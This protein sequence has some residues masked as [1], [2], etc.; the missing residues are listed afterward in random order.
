MAEDAI[1]SRVRALLAKAESTP[2]PE[3]AHA[4]TAKAQELMIR[5]AIDEAMLGDV[6][7]DAG[8][9]MIMAEVWIE[10][11]F[12]RSKGALLNV[13]GTTNRCWV[14]G[15]A[16]T[17]NGEAKSRYQVFG[18]KR[19]VDFVETLFTSLLLQ[20]QVE[21]VK[22]ECDNENAG[23]EMGNMK[24][25]RNVFMVA[26][27]NGIYRRLK[28]VNKEVEKEAP[29]VGLVLADQARQAEAFGR[30]AVGGLVRSSS[31]TVRDHA[32]ASKAGSDAAK[33]ASIHKGQMGGRRAIGQG[34]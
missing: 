11:P 9:E 30:E 4:F 1:L 33:R 13:V 29:G 8:A 3:E 16:S 31:R 5:H 6:G 18:R 23:V 10:K 15:P 34:N 27:S 2:F 19:D 7:G 12:I 25:W 22:S 24:T 21:M 20:A 14:L 32:G 26:Y 17:R 28:D